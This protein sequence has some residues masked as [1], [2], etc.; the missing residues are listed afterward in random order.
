MNPINL[1]LL[2]ICPFKECPWAYILFVGG[3]VI[4]FVAGY[5]VCKSKMRSQAV[6]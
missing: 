4:G 2:Y 5:V 3:L 1:L 6:K